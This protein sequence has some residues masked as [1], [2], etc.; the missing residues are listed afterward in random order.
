ME[1]GNRD[2]EL[3]A[4]RERVRAHNFTEIASPGTIFPE[5]RKKERHSEKFHGLKLSRKR[6]LIFDQ[7]GRDENYHRERR[8]CGGNWE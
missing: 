4:K 1:G 6:K 8:G 2:E 5:V 7:K 3:E